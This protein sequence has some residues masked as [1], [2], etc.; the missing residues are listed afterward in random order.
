MSEV[1]L[2]IYLA[3][4]PFISLC[5]D[6]VHVHAQDLRTCFLAIYDLKNVSL[7][8]G[9]SCRRNIYKNEWLNVGAVC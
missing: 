5:T 3:P 4:P 8:A 2:F 7:C 1:Y 6:S 9:H